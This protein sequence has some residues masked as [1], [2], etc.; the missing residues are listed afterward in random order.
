MAHPDDHGYGYAA[1]VATLPVNGQFTPDQV[2]RFQRDDIRSCWAIIT[3]MFS[4]FFI[5]LLG[6]AT[7][8]LIVA[9]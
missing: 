8:S 1:H 3:L 6:A 7:I 2:E 9:G 4:V 5:G